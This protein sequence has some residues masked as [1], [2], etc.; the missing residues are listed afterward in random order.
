MAVVDRSIMAETMASSGQEFVELA[1]RL[2]AGSGMGGVAGGTAGGA[3][4]ATNTLP[5][6]EGAATARWRRQ[7]LSERILVAK[8]VLY[9]DDRAVADWERALQYASLPQSAK[10]V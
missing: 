3:N 6:K 10:R 9:E 7:Q 4:G 8:H 5:G 2:A 1:L